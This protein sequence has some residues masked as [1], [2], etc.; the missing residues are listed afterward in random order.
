MGVVL[1][2]GWSEI[3]WTVSLRYLSNGLLSQQMLDAIKCIADDSTIFQQ[4]TALVH[5]AFNTVQLV[6]CKTLK[7]PFSS[8]MSP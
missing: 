2:Q 4:D 1:Y 6:Q 8:A 5:P 3:Q 7:L